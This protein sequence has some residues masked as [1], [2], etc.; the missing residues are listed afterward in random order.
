MGV[1]GRVM[2]MQTV[3]GLDGGW[4]G[5]EGNGMC[6]R[7]VSPVKLTMLRVGRRS[8]QHHCNILGIS[9]LSLSSSP[10]IGKKRKDAESRWQWLV[11]NN[12]AKPCPQTGKLKV[13][14][15]GLERHF[16]DESRANQ[17]RFCTCM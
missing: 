6:P 1:G 5:A 13:V 3:S 2:M 10:H 14:Q 15:E 16:E 17:Q 9:I 12:I 7:H 11:Q 8:E 4:H